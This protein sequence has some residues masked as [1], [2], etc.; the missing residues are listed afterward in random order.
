MSE[1]L[2]SELPLITGEIPLGYDLDE[3]YIWRLP[4]STP[5]SRKY[6]DAPSGLLASLTAAEIVRR[7]ESVRLRRVELFDKAAQQRRVAEFVNDILASR[8]ASGSGTGAQT[9]CAASQ[10]VATPA[11]ARDHGR[12]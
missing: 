7:R 2:A 4:G 6:V 8:S 3:G 5:W 9:P 11:S 10:R 1:Y 12:S